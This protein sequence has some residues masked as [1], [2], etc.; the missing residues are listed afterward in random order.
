MPIGARGVDVDRHEGD[1]L[2]NRYP[3]VCRQGLGM[4]MYIDIQL[5]VE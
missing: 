5:H 2:Y 1:M 3:Y 4:E